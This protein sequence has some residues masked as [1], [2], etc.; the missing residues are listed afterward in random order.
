MIVKFD[1]AYKEYERVEYDIPNGEAFYNDDLTNYLTKHPENNQ[2]DFIE[3]LRDNGKALLVEEYSVGDRE[4]L[5]FIED[6]VEF[7]DEPLIYVRI[8][9]RSL[10]NYQRTYHIIYKVAL[11]PDELHTKFNQFSQ[12]FNGDGL[13]F[14]NGLASQ[15]VAFCYC[16]STD[17]QSYMMFN[18]V[19]KGINNPEK[20]NYMKSSLKIM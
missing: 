11:T 14:L 5:E 20:H 12:L 2:K 7:E 3:H 8:N 15:G 13:V 10:T 6:S 19:E 1:V 18:P 16:Y 4:Y 17:I 9:V